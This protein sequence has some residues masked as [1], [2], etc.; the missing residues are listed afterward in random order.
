MVMTTSELR[1]E[2]APPCSA[3]GNT[4]RV[5]YQS[6]DD[7]FRKHGYVVKAGET[8]AYNCRQITNGSSWSLH[9]YGPGDSFRFWTGV[10]I[11]MSLAVDVNWNSNPYGP[12]LVT[13]MSR[14]MI[15]DV[16]G[17]E[18]N[19]GARVWGWGGYYSTNKDAMHFEIVCSEEDLASG[20]RPALPTLERGDKGNYVQYL[21]GMLNDALKL[22]GTARLAT[23]GLWG[24]RYTDRV[25][26][27]VTWFQGSRG[28]GKDGVVGPA[29]W[30]ALIAATR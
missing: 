10:T 27:Y 20:I 22:K 1:V 21:R 23:N 12:R 11:A 5:A 9:A 4:Y 19:S 15:A 16:Y 30:S 28:L 17:I 29:T 13:D 18:T 25:A 3:K 24:N 26:R 7:V 8:G 2:Y 14:E 6:L